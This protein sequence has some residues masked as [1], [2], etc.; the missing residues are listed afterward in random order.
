MGESLI[1][2]VSNSR[3]SQDAVHGVLA[4]DL[5]FGLS[6]SDVAHTLWP[7]QNIHEKMMTLEYQDADAVTLSVDAQYSLQ[8]GVIVQ[9]TGYLQTLVS[10]MYIAPCFLV[11]S[12][13]ECLGKGKVM[14]L[15]TS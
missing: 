2:I 5:H 7:M 15:R 9:V 10:Q 6:L 12:R 13:M 3:S 8:Q 14:I 11:G 1:A 4:S